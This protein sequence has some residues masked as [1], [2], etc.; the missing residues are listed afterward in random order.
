MLLDTYKNRIKTNK[1]FL[2]VD[3]LYSGIDSVE[4]APAVDSNS[5]FIDSYIT[6]Q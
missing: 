6:E 1:F 2:S 3:R 5:P 4:P